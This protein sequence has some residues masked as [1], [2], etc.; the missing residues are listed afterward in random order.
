[1]TAQSSTKETL[2]ANETRRFRVLVPAS[3]F[4]IVLGTGGLANSW[5]AATDLWGVQ[6]AIGEILALM[7]ALI[8]VAL[9]VFYALKWIR[10]PSDAKAEMEHPVQC[11]FVGLLGV[12]TALVGS[13]VSPYLGDLGHVLY[14]LGATATASFAV[15]RTGALWKGGR[16][17]ASTTAVLYLPTVAGFYVIAIAGAPLGYADIGKLAFGAGF[18]SWLAIESVLLNRLLTAPE[19]P[20]PLRPTIGIQLAPPAVGAA[21]YLSVTTGAPDMLAHAMVGYAILQLLLMMRIFPWVL[22]Q[23]VNASYWGFSFGLTALATDVIR[24]A[25]RGEPGLLHYLAFPFLLLVSAAIA[26]LAINS[27][28]LL[29]ERKLF[30]LRAIDD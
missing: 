24:L 26:L 1:M 27:I 10:F 17:L 28:R 22:N 5:R 4:G 29:A 21:A 8:W 20:A 7:A 3:A 14:W 19:M 15:W 18:F 2:A 23:P 12:A 25:Q 11:C 13:I 6:A 16:D 30:P 9:L